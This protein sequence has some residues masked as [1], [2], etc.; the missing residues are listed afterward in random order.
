MVG[1]FKNIVLRLEHA[2]RRTI[3]PK[4]QHLAICMR[5]YHIGIFRHWKKGGSGELNAQRR[6]LVGIG[7][8][9]KELFELSFILVRIF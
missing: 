2:N 6:A 8:D 3:Q 5:D 7:G 1:L 4:D 9:L